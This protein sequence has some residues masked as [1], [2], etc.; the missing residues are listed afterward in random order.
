MAFKD[1]YIKDTEENRKLFKNY[2]ITKSGI[3]PILPRHVP[4]GVLRTLHECSFVFNGVE[5]DSLC[6]LCDDAIRCH[7]KGRR[8]CYVEREK[9]DI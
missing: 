4:S 9:L 8:V 6:E 5:Y 1:T 7:V 2:V 3:A